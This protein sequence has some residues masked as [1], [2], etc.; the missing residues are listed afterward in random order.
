MSRQ[1]RSV[2]ME[3]FLLTSPR[4][5]FLIVL[6]IAIPIVRSHSIPPIAGTGLLTI[7][8]LLNGR[9]AHLGPFLLMSH[10]PHW[11]LCTVTLG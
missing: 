2:S 6:I 4:V 7:A 11:H 5:V 8:L 9:D 1:S 10:R 3:V